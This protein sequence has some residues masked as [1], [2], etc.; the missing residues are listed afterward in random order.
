MKV[1]KYSNIPAVWSRIMWGA[2]LQKEL[3]KKKQLFL[4]SYYQFSI[5]MQS[6]QFYKPLIVLPWICLR[7]TV[8]MHV[9]SNILVYA[10]ISNKIYL[11]IQLLQSNILVYSNGPSQMS[12]CIGVSV[13]IQIFSAIQTHI[14]FT[15]QNQTS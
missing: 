15:L 12:P 3:A 8:N 5:V 11:C 10:N 4:I 7:L 2:S 14:I 9:Y 1:Y 13:Q 6:V